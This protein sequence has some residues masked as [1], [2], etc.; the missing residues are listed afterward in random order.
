MEKQISKIITTAI[1][2]GSILFL[3]CLTLINVEP[4]WSEA[5]VTLA[6]GL[7]WIGGMGFVYLWL[8]RKA[9][10]WTWIDT[11]AGIWMAYWLLRVWVGAEYPCGT[12]FM[13]W[14]WMCLLYVLLR[15]VFTGCRQWMPYVLAM[16]ILMG[17]AIE[18]V[19]G[20]VQMLNGSSRHGMFLLTG[21]FLNPGPYS[22]YPM[23]GAVIGMVLLSSRLGPNFCPG[24]Y[25]CGITPKVIKTVIEVLMLTC[26]MVLPA[27]WSR[28]A[29][30]G[31]G[32]VA[33]W[34]F[35][36]R[37]WQ[38]RWWLW[39]SLLALAIVAF[40]VKQGSAEG[41]LITWSAALVSWWQEPW[42]GV[43]FGGFRHA[44]AEG[45][46]TLYGHDSHLFGDFRNAGVTEYAC[47]AP[48]QILVEQGLTG[49][50]LCCGAAAVALK[51]M[52]AVCRPLLFCLLSLLLFSCFSY[53]FEMLPYRIIL[54]LALALTASCAAQTDEKPHAFW[55]PA[56]LG[57]AAIAI[58]LP[59][60]AETAARLDDEADTRVI[61]GMHDDFFLK[62]LY[63]SLPLNRDNPTILFRVAQLLQDQ[64]RWRDSNAVLRMGTEV[65]ADPMF[66][67]LQGNNYQ[68][69][70]FDNLAE[71]AYLK[72][73]A[74][75]PNRLYPLYQ[76]MLLYQKIGRHPQALD[77]ARQIVGMEPKIQSP[78]TDEMQRK[79]KELL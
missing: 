38:W 75:M 16:L 77:V 8:N 1:Q 3:L 51:K 59:L 66:Y 30:V 13:Q 71:E 40:F 62:D 78:A 67:V 20:F 74:I 41:R 34:A 55:R 14:A 35:R 6:K 23:M 44:V 54:V 61:A 21:S 56:L 29:W 26:L 5:D 17:G 64:Q 37:Y 46:A 12:A 68:Q 58:S 27:T 45:I 4:R 36:S 52:H 57:C 76:L 60:G 19:W 39:S 69:M 18:S 24:H 7:P 11:L 31:T 15:M 73:F 53:P 43:G 48:L 10:Q 32:L 22:A 63:S 72:A 42:F 47:N 79:A 33:L 70:G 25:C 2:I 50:L 28:A 65:S 9:W 49:A